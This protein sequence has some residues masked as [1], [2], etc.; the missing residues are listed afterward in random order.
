MTQTVQNST[1]AASVAGAITV[2]V[3]WAVETWTPL[4]IPPEVASSSTAIIMALLTHFVP[5]APKSVPAAL[6]GLADAPK[7]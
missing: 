4:A 3:A 7:G 1:F 2:I 6:P 5:D